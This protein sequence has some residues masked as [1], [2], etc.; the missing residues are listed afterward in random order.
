[1]FSSCLLCDNFLAQ[2][3]W[4]LVGCISPNAST[5]VSRP[6]YWPMCMP[7]MTNYRENVYIIFAVVN[8]SGKFKLCY[9]LKVFSL[10]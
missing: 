10:V 1:M 9:M 6:I 2:Q 7:D 3:F 5:N 4:R 8:P